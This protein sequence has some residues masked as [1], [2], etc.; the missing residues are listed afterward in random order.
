VKE[1]LGDTQADIKQAEE[2]IVTYGKEMDKIAKVI[3]ALCFSLFVFTLT[4]FTYS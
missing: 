4:V 3:N 1:A 2:E